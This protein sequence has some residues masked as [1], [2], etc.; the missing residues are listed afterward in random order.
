MLSVATTSGGGVGE[1]IKVQRVT[2]SGFTITWNV[3]DT[4][5]HQKGY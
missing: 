4:T 2:C 3:E 5:E 1:G